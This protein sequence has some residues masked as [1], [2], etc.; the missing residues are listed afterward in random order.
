MIDIIHD[1][2]TSDFCFAWGDTIGSMYNIFY[3]NIQNESIESRLKSLEKPWGITMKRLLAKLD[4]YSGN[5]NIIK[6]EGTTSYSAFPCFIRLI[7][8][9]RLCLPSHSTGLS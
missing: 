5:E 1:S 2:V 3:D 8:L 6:R 4:E 9:R 7:L